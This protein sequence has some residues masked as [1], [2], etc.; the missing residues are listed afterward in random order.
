VNIENQRRYELAERLAAIIRTHPQVRAMAIAGSVAQGVADEVSDID[1]VVYYEQTPTREELEAFR[2][3]AGGSNWIF[4]YG[5]PAE[6]G[7]AISFACEGIK[8]DFAISTL[9]K[10]E[11]NME[12]VLTLHKADS[13]MQKALSGILDA[14]PL[15]GEA[16]ITL[17]K[18]Q[19]AEY[20]DALAEA[21]VK[22]HLKFYPP[23]VTERMVAK[24]G[25]LLFLYEIFTEAGKNILGVLMGL[26]RRYHWGE[27]KRT[28][29]LLAGLE[30]APPNLAERLHRVLRDEPETA[31]QEL[32]T[33][34]EDTFLLIEKHL[35]Q[36]DISETV[37]RYRRP[38]G[39]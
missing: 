39:T 25:D 7:C 33:L 32:H 30:I 35:P 26:N 27:F 24:R 36:L 17:W 15:F 3:Q 20:P 14:V 22:K 5:D 12:E 28:D 9:A 8:C 4:F 18:G 34:I 6:G 23:W 16:Y 29:A 38:L 19:A 21:M 37:H 31:A 11:D 13:P 1:M 2:E 10:W